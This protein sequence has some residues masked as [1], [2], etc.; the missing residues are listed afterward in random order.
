[1]RKKY[2]FLLLM[3]LCIPWA[4][5]SQ[6]VVAVDE[7]FNNVSTTLPTGWIRSGNISDVSNWHIASPYQSGY[8]YDGKYL[9]M[10]NYVFGDSAIVQT[11]SFD[12]TVDM[13]LTFMLFNPVCL[14]FKVYVVYSEAGETR[15]A[16]L[17][18]C[19]NNTNWEEN[20]VSLQPYMGKTGARIMFQAVSSG[21]VDKYTWA[22]LDNVKVFETPLCA[23]PVSLSLS[24]LTDTTATLSWSL[25][26]LGS[27]SSNYRFTLRDGNGQNVYN[28]ASFSTSGFN[29]YTVSGLTPNSDYTVILQSDCSSSAQGYSDQSDEFAFHTPANPVSLPYSVTFEG[30]NALPDGWII[31]TGRNTSDYSLSTVAHNGLKALALPGKGTTMSV[32]LP[33]FDAPADSM[34]ADFYIQT[35]KKT[36]VRVGLISDLADISTFNELYN[37]EINALSQ[38]HNI[39]LTTGAT[40]YGND[41]NKYLCLLIYTENDGMVYLDDV[42]VENV[43]SCSRLEDLKAVPDSTNITLSW[44]EY[45]TVPT[46]NYQ[47]EYATSSATNY[48]VL[49]SNPAVLSNVDENSD[50]TVRVRAICAAGDTSEWS[51]P[52][53]VHT[54]CRPQSALLYETFDGQTKFDDCWTSAQTVLGTGSGTGDYG[55]GGWDVYTYSGK[56]RARLRYARLGGHYI[57]A[58][59]PLSIAN[60]GQYD[61]TFSLYRYSNSINGSEL[62]VWASH[63]TDTVGAVLIT[64]IARNYQGVPEE[65]K[66]GWY[67]YEVNIPLSGSVYVLF[68]GTHI[69]STSASY[70]DSIHIYEAPKCRAPKKL[71]V[72]SSLNT[73]DLSWTAGAADHNEWRVHYT[74]YWG[75]NDSL[76]Y[77]GTVN[78]TQ[79]SVPNLNP[80]TSY[81]IVGYVAT[82]CGDALYSDPLVIDEYVSTACPVISTFPYVQD[83]ENVNVI[84]PVCW[85][86]HVVCNPTRGNY[87][88]EDIWTISDN[89]LKAHGGKGA[90][91]FLPAGQKAVVSFVT[92]K[93]NF[94]SGKNYQVRF[95]MHRSD[96]NVYNYKVYLRA[97][98][99]DNA[100]DT[101]G[102]R[103]CNLPATMNAEP[104]EQKEGYY[105][106][107]F[108]I[109]SNIAG[110]KYIVFAGVNTAY[111]GCDMYIDD[112]VIE[113]VPAC[114]KIQRIHTSAISY[115]TA[116]LWIEAEK[117][118]SWQYVALKDGENIEDATPVSVSVNDSTVVTGLEQLTHYRFF[119]RRDCGN[120]VYSEWSANYAELTTPCVEGRAPYLETFESYA[121][122]S[123]ITENCFDFERNSSYS[124]YPYIATSIYDN[125]AYSGKQCVYVKHRG[126]M[127][128]QFYLES[129]K[130]YEMSVFAIGSPDEDEAVYGN[131]MTYFIA[132]TPSSKGIIYNFSEKNQIKPVW[133]RIS[134]T[135]TIAETGYYYLGIQFIAQ[136]ELGIDNWSLREVACVQ[137]NNIEISSLT[138]TT[139][140]LMFQKNGQQTEVRVSTVNNGD[141]DP[142]FD[143][144]IDTISNNTVQLTGLQ[145]RTTY[146]YALRSVCDGSKS[147]W[148]TIKSFMTLCTPASLPYSDSFEDGNTSYDCWSSIGTNKVVESTTE[149]N[150]K[151]GTKSVKLQ[152][153]TFTSPNFNADNL[154]EY[155]VTG[156]VYSET[157]TSISLGVQGDP[158]STESYEHLYDINVTVPNSWTEFTFNLDVL[159]SEDY[160]GDPVANYKYVAFVVGADIVYLDNVSITSTTNCVRPS[161]IRINNFNPNQLDV[162]WT[163]G[164]SETEWIVKTYRYRTLLDGS[165]D[166]TLDRTDTVSTSHIVMRNMY[167]TTRY[168]LT[169]ESR[170]GAGD[171]SSEAISPDFTTGCATVSLP[172][173]AEIMTVTSKGNM[174]SCW[175]QGDYEP[176]LKTNLWNAYSSQGLMWNYSGMAAVAHSTILTPQFDFT[177][178]ISAK[179][180]MKVNVMNTDTMFIFASYD[181]GMTFTDTIGFMNPASGSATE[182]KTFEVTKCSG[183]EVM[184]AIRAKCISA[185]ESEY[186]AKIQDFA[187]EPVERCIIPEGAIINVQSSNE[188]RVVINDTVSTH[189]VW[190]YAVVLSGNRVSEAT[191]VTVNNVVFSING[192]QPNTDYDLY[193]RSNCGNNDVSSWRGPISFQTKCNIVNVP[194]YESFENDYSCYTTCLSA[195]AGVLYPK[196]ERRVGMFTDGR[197]SLRFVS[198]TEFISSGRSYLVMPETDMEI[199]KLGISFDYLQRPSSGKFIVG[200]MNGNDTSTFIPYHTLDFT[201][202]HSFVSVDFKFFNVPAEYSDYQIAI[203]FTCGTSYNVDSYIDNVLVYLADKYEP[204][205]RAEF[206]SITTTSAEVTFDCNADYIEVS[207]VHQG[208][209]PAETGNITSATQSVALTGLTQS[210]GYAVYVRT[211]S[212]GEISEWFGPYYFYTDCGL[213]DITGGWTEN[214]DSYSVNGYAMAPCF[215]RAQT[216]MADGED[217]PR[218]KSSTIKSMPNALVMKGTNILVLPEFNVLPG[219]VVFSCDLIGNDCDLIVGTI[220]NDDIST[221]SELEYLSATGVV[222]HYTVNLSDYLCTGNR[223]ALRTKMNSSIVYIDDINVSLP[224]STPVTTITNVDAQDFSATVR[225]NVPVT[226]LRTIY[227]LYNAADLTSPVVTDSTTGTTI[228]L[229]GLT[230]NTD[231]VINLRTVL[232][233]GTS[234]AT[235]VANFKTTYSVLRVPFVI[236]FES[237]ESNAAWSVYTNK[238]DRFIFGSNVNA[239]KSGNKALYVSNNPSTETYG[240]TKE[241]CTTYATRTVYLSEGMVN[242]SFDYKIKGYLSSDFGRVFLMPVESEMPEYGLEYDLPDGSFSLDYGMPMSEQ[243]DVWQNRSM[244]L[245]I[246]EAGYYNIVVYWLACGYYDYQPPLAVDNFRFSSVPCSVLENI[247]V[248]PSHNAATITYDG[249]TEGTTINYVIKEG[250]DTIT[251]GAVNGSKITVSGLEPSTDYTYVVFASCGE[252]VASPISGNFTTCC[253]PLYAPWSYGF[254]D[255]SADQPLVDANPCWGQISSSSANFIGST[256]NGTTFYDVIH[257]N[258]SQSLLL[259][260]GIGVK[261]MFYNRFHFDTGKQYKFSAWVRNSDALNVGNEV[262]IVLI[263]DGIV[264]KTFASVELTDLWQNLSADIMMSTAGDYQLGIC[265]LHNYYDNSSQYNMIATTIDDVEFK[266][267]VNIAPTPV[268]IRNVT[269]DGA[270][271]HWGNI[272]SSYKVEIKRNETVVHSAIV[273]DTTGYTVTGLNSSTYYQVSVRGIRG[274]N[275][276][277]SAAISAF[278]TTC[279]TVEM[280][281]HENFDELALNSVPSCWS[282]TSNSILASRSSNWGVTRINDNEYVMA[283]NTSTA[284]GL[285][286]LQSMPVTITNADAGI[287]FRYNNGSDKSKLYVILSNDGGATLDTI[288]FAGK[289]DDWTEFNYSLTNYY[290]QDVTLYFNTISTTAHNAVIAFDDLRINATEFMPVVNDTICQGEPYY[291]YGFSYTASDLNV[292]INSFKKIKTSA[293][294]NPID[295]VISVELLVAPKYFIS[296]Y[297]TICK[298]DV[299]NEGLFANVTP[300]ITT[301]GRYERNFISSF[302]CDSTV[303]LYLTV[304]D[305]DSTIYVPLCEGSTYTF[306]GETYS[307]AGVHTITERNANGCDVTTTIDI[308]LIPRYYDIYV[309]Q[310]DDV[311]YPWEGQMI[312]TTGVYTANYKNVNGC[313]SIVRL[314]YTALPTHIDTTVTICSG[315]NYYFAGNVLTEAGTYH[316]EFV[317]YFGCDSIVNL[318]LVVTE[319]IHSVVNDFVCEGD[320]YISNGFALYE[321]TEDTI[322]EL[323][324]STK[325]GC[326]SIVELHLKLIPIVYDTIRAHINDGETYEFGNNTYSQAGEY[327]S[328]YYTEE[329]GCD[330]IVTL[331]LTVGTGVD[332]SYVL[333]VVIAP[334]PILGGQSTFVN[335]E[336]TMEEQNGMRVEILNSVGMLMKEFTPATFPIEINGINVAGVYIIRI[337]SGT[338]ETYIGRLVVK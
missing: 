56:K 255:L 314:H 260:S 300:P 123:L 274:A 65:L 111:N 129:G 134:A 172:Y 185:N 217:Y 96:I 321:V 249:Y 198:A 248:K 15:K 119:V 215:T 88:G 135:F 165:T 222:S 90:G 106:Y 243:N 25:Y 315:S 313:D 332:D 308:E 50:Y 289:S 114:S 298:G 66:A 48:A 268:E 304:L 297:D 256:G 210:T 71:N 107:I 139:A 6:S 27:V 337:T 250:S 7:N 270:E 331:I 79:Y 191:P 29:F 2:F 324:L 40:T 46:G 320:D 133:S 104:I 57:L 54:S 281:Y 120:G 147:S 232:Q 138:T 188:V 189:N 301:S 116:S 283:V 238:N 242:V 161:D 60:D 164:G 335:R 136:S 175:S 285:L 192:L 39:R 162:T 276:T 245:K 177:N 262:S 94:Q 115:S 166:V 292:G 231:Y 174:P 128:R 284:N 159:A 122:G 303:A 19:P 312:S 41:G 224:T 178:V 130:T 253:T 336:W 299:Y 77:D 190:D 259:R 269:S 184:F 95:W 282:N 81:H 214:F 237:E 141:L 311:S 157:A 103:L 328:T 99:T 170:C 290:G 220:Q 273:S 102:E 323:S 213:I 247:V 280:P 1:M 3:L 293:A 216:Y 82:K 152:N 307:E 294:E 109:P 149:Q 63:T 318:T 287:S 137:P 87:F 20:V 13:S 252:G 205:T 144:L 44:I 202:L 47:V 203:G 196:I 16:L 155:T 176:E 195:D 118:V 264:V 127:F 254:E 91:H 169:V 142:A 43:G 329:Y 67:N 145:P 241:A 223:I 263:E 244:Q 18:D 212:E 156:Y 291:K 92:P 11:P 132:R 334:N 326:D 209:A 140:Q 148:S 208:D 68:E 26:G 233:D 45:N 146:Y 266:E 219:Q 101:I 110:E 275:D 327:Q 221:F 317:S 181:G 10:S 59:P 197:Y 35:T 322:A 199:Q 179:V 83:F 108:E 186:F 236:D 30:M 225:F 124:K 70:L 288:L 61:L 126:Y 74:V 31:G 338:G 84:P 69:N 309:T 333:P 229:S 187:I 235:S 319:P 150:Y 8:E 153:C 200:I 267:I 180:T 9:V 230:E 296:L 21:N 5:F 24:S 55:S 78:S 310:C 258:G 14:D 75:E 105:E 325:D 86:R 23:R 193:I 154:S 49:T 261:A 76:V 93:F 160:Q 279:G 295:T 182:T 277:T 32:V 85:N 98:V 151:A 58:T 302:G 251:S 211:H 112:V 286:S 194:Y 158:Y 62:K 143:I 240:Y 51:L 246:T 207:C 271:I 72:T 183:R 316:H 42:R 305:L 4:V 173:D 226:A 12:I 171:F 100:T 330:S 64:T 22:Y 257:H 73:I 218:I 204:V 201:E 272:C 52:V 278:T 33:A 125:E 228:T 234:T 168:Y 113:E 131:K 227:T 36:S 167:P 117:N 206:S 34:M 239:V 38:W 37:T 53:T 163:P 265:V 17:L 28:N 89:S 97:F 121:K 306:N 80:A